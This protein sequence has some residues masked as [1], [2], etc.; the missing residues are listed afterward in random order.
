LGAQTAAA[1]VLAAAFTS[2]PELTLPALGASA[3]TC[4]LPQARV[5]SDVSITGN[6]PQFFFFQKFNADYD[7]SAKEGAD[8]LAFISLMDEKLKPALIYTFWIEP[9]NY[10]DVT[11]RWFAEHLP[12]PLNFFLPGRMLADLLSGSPTGTKPASPLCLSFLLQLYRDATECLNL[13]S[14]RLGSQKFFFGDSPSSLDAYVF[15]HLAPI[16]RCKLPNGKLQQHLKS[17]DNLANFCSNILL[18]YFPRDGRALLPVCLLRR[19]QSDVA[20]PAGRWRLRQRPQQAAKAA[21][22]RCGGP[23]RHAELRPPHRHRVHPARPAGGAGGAAR[24]G[25]HGVPRR[26][27]GRLRTQAVPGLE[28]FRTDRV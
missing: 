28:P 24:P 14:Q 2:S 1:G 18:L 15:G 27:R 20:P 19:L 10:V 11:R 9:K 25:G 4:P 17:L 13:L 23:G 12:F 6:M 8:S 21:A 5:R 16:L 22:L 3:H 26:G 7:L